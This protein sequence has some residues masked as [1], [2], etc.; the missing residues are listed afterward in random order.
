MIAISFD[1]PNDFDAWRLLARRLLVAA[2]PPE[3]VAWS[4]AGEGGLLGTPDLPAPVRATGSV[5]KGFLE[6]AQTAICHRAPERFGLLYRFLWRLVEDRSLL[7]QASDAD[8]IAL[9]R[10]ASAVRRDSHKMK[11]FLRF[12]TV[13]GT[14]GV[15]RFLAWFEPDHFVLDRVAPFLVRRFTGMIWGVVTPD[16][17]A[18]W[19]GQDL[20]FG[21]GG[22]KSD[23]PAS[24]GL[25]DAWRT[26][27]ESIFNPARLKVKMMT[28]EMPKKYWRNLPEAERIDPLIRAA[29]GAMSA[30]IARPAEPAPVRHV[31]QRERAADTAGET[32]T[33]TDTAPTSLAAART[34]IDG[35]RRCGLYE[36]ATQ[37][38][39]GEGPETARV[40]FVGE[41]PGDQEDLAGKPFV[42]PAGQVFDACLAEAG[43]HRSEVY[44]T[45]AV[46][47]FKFVPRG[48]RRIHQRPDAGEVVACRFWLDL[49]RAFVKPPIVVALGATA[50]HSLLGKAVTI[51]KA[52]GA[53]IALEDGSTLF[54]TNHPSYLLRI[55]D[56]EGRAKERARF[57]QDLGIVRDA[58]AG[59][60]TSDGRARHA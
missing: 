54:V 44:V 20:V 50:A 53:P 33:M 60:E 21:P 19:D 26:Y 56:A 41:Q 52:R 25:E 8:L 49:E 35:C 31:R 38:V 9:N 14:D 12:R 46:K 27:Y 48:K 16:R 51:S 7:E 47:H 6:L 32:A 45:N 39:F 30:M 40:L 4:M 28:S 22:R 23:V 10:M 57:I 43:I 18:H 11:A 36:Q 58:L 15:E 42:G 5:P 59:L 34:A 55:P 29:G 2:V 37:P 1:S 13:P 3:D 24:D 17:S